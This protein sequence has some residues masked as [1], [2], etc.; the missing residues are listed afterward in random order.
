MAEWITDVFNVIWNWF[1]TALHAVL[2]PV[3]NSL[4]SAINTLSGWASLAVTLVTTFVPYLGFANAWAPVS[5]FFQLLAAYS[6]F[7]LSLVIYRSVKKWIPTLS[8]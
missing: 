8:G 6:I 3:V 7:W 4:T 1:M 2:D 5:L